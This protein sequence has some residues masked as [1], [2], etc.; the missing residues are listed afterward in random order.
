M[1][2]KN[3]A[4]AQHSD[5]VRSLSY[6]FMAGQRLKLKD[7]VIIRCINK[8]KFEQ[9]KMTESSGWGQTEEIVVYKH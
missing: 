4:M 9:R 5:Q 6:T 8:L 7:H 1:S 2:N 3:D